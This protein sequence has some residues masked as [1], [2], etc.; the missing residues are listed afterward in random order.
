MKSRSLILSLLLAGCAVGPEYQQP[1]IALENR[2][3]DGSAE[4]IGAVAAERWW[5]G[6]NDAVL[7]ELVSRGLTQSL[8]VMSATE[9]IREAQAN[10]RATGVNSALDGSLSA[11]STAAGGDGISGSVTTNSATLGAG[12]VLDLFGGLR[13]EQNAAAASLTAARAASETVRLAWLAELVSAYSNARYYQEVLA[14]TRATISSREETVGIIG[15]QLEAGAATEYEV[16]EAKALLSSARA[17]LP[18]YAALFDANV[19]AIAT[20]LN[21]P[22]GPIMTQM[23]KGARQLSAPGAANTGVPADLLRNRHDVRSAEADLAAAV[24]AVGVAE[25]SLY[26]SL[27]LT[28]T[29][30]RTDRA[31]SW[32]FG[33]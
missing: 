8:D 32:G 3:A 19:Y 21:E 11:S 27:S 30:G 18:Q 26:P 1:E 15:S 13:Y 5:V 9:A 4:S 24:A 2:F 33:P 22:A 20:L 10:L 7:S 17:S 29:I 23:Q 31:D 16:A 6:Y 14:L 28:G 12:L 25:A